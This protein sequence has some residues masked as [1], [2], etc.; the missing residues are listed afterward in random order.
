MSVLT[1]IVAMFSQDIGTLSYLNFD[2][3]QSVSRIQ[4]LILCMAT[5]ISS[6]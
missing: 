1:V 6:D 3:I 4:F 2:F 5:S